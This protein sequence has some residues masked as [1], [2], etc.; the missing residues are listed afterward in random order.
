[1][2]GLSP[3]P[4]AE[5]DARF[6][7]ARLVEILPRVGAHLRTVGVPPAAVEECQQMADTLRSRIQTVRAD[8]LMAIARA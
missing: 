3:F 4:R 6:E 7:L 1:M 8:A 2:D 5:A